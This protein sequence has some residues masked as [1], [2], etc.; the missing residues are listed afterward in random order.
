MSDKNS[1]IKSNHDLAVPLGRDNIS[2]SLWEW[3]KNIEKELSI[4]Y[5]P[6]READKMREYYEEAGLLAS[7]KV[8]FFRRHFC[9]TFVRASE[10]LLNE[11]SQPHILDLGCGTGSQAIFLALMGAKVTGLDMDGAALEILRKRKAMYEELSGKT[12]NIE[13]MEQSAFDVDYSLLAPIDG[14]YSMFAFNM[15]QPSGRLLDALKP[16][17]SADARI[18]IIDGNSASWLPLVMR[19]RRRP[20]WS[21]QE[22]SARLMA[23]GFT[24]HEHLG[25]V[26]IPAPFWKVSPNFMTPLDD[27]LNRNWFFPISHQILAER[28]IKA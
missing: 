18:A 25:G 27:L 24:I 4:E 12:L 7:W 2:V 15:M 21:P 23:A 22:F 10:F 13:L 14:V 19:S 9:E 28:K 16:G 8:D 26:A 3:Y 6:E 11:R 5:L 17:L 20:V 1:M